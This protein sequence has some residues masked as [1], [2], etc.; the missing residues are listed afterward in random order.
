[1]ACKACFGC[2]RSSVKYNV[3]F[4]DC[5]QYCTPATQKQRSQNQVKGSCISA[6]QLHA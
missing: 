5:T 3:S 1:M 4:L 2:P 6:V